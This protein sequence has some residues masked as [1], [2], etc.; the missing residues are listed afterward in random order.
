MSKSLPSVGQVI[1]GDFIQRNFVQQ[2]P[3]SQDTEFVVFSRSLM[4]MFSLYPSSKPDDNKYQSYW[5]VIKPLVGKQCTM[6]E[7]V[8]AMKNST[9]FSPRWPLSAGEL[10]TLAVSKFSQDEIATAFATC[11]EGGTEPTLTAL[12]QLI[13]NNR[14]RMQENKAIQPSLTGRTQYVSPSTQERE[15]MLEHIRRRDSKNPEQMERAL[16]REI[17]TFALEDQLAAGEI[18]E[19]AFIKAIKANIHEMLGM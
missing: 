14:K 7:I 13:K 16:A 5:N 10:M 1:S 9:Y 2:P 12:S 6:L 4:D 18:T 19:D 11:T 3:Q 15:S 17:K 8:G